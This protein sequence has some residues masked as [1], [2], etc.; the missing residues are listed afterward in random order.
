MYNKESV[1]TLPFFISMKFNKKKMEQK[2]RRFHYLFLL[3]TKYCF[4]HFHFIPFCVCV[5]VFVC[6]YILYRPTFRKSSTAGFSNV[7]F[8][9]I[10]GLITGKYIFTEPLKLYWEEQQE[11]QLQVQ[12]QQQQNQKG[13]EG[14]Q[15]E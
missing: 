3:I 7:I 13:E 4:L 5:F 9:S 1:I 14:G 11:L 10:V 2:K 15:K 12:Q 8:G 6:I